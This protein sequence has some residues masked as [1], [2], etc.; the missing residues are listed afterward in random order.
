[1]EIAREIAEQ[2]QAEGVTMPSLRC[3]MD[4]VIELWKGS[5]VIRL[6]PDE[7]RFVA[8]QLSALVRCPHGIK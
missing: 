8:N 1:M 7:A 3:I 2:K 4:G 6:L 5:N